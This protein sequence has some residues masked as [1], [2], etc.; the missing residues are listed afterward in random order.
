MIADRYLRLRSELKTA[1]AGLLKLGSEMRPV[2]SE[3]DTLRTL[4]TDIRDPLLVVAVGEVKSGKSSLLNALF[5]QEFA[6][7]DVLPATDRVYIFR[8]GTEEKSV[9]VSPQL[10]ERYLPIAFLRDFK[11]IDTPGTN[12]MRSEHQMIMENF[13]PR[14]DLVLFVFS[15]ANPWTQSNWDFLRLVQKKWLKNGVFVLQ[16]IDLREPTEIEVIRRHLQDTVMRKLGFV[17]PI[18][19]VSARKALLAG[20]TGSDKEHLWRESDFGPLQE[21]INLIVTESS[22][23]MLKLRSACQAAREMLDE[24]ATE[25]RESFNA[26]SGDEAAL[27]HVDFLLQTRKDQTLR[28]VAGLLCNVEQACREAAAHGTK[29]LKEKLPF[30]RTW[31]LIWSRKPWQHDDFQTEIE[32]KLPQSVQAHIEHAV[33]LLE[34]DLRGLWPQL[35]DMIDK[36]LASELQ[37]Q[38]PQTITDFA[39]QRRELLESIQLALMEQ[40]AGKSAEEQLTQMFHETVAGGIV[41]LIAARSSAAVADATGILAASAAAV[42]TIV[43]LRRRRKILHAYEEQMESKRSELMKAIEQQLEHAI[44]LFYKEFAS[45]FHP[46]AAFCQARRSTYESLLESAEELQRI[47]D[48]LKSRLR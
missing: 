48:G 7:V 41:A 16:Q 26:I 21:Q 3:M 1:L 38:I 24:F 12:T 31:K 33:G 6:K 25:L 44:G 40:A 17:P 47:F 11:V 5:G 36:Q 34:A 20:T 35:H 14:A 2:S 45:A 37:E 42:V 39:R 32:A 9:E 15:V 23:A 30:W 46:L 4:M 22:T 28:Q 19:A 10:T 43:A 18:F 29:L 27:A 8:Y 13:V